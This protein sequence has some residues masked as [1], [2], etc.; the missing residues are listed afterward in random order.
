MLL[1][2]VEG[3]GALW[4][5][6][7]GEARG[8]DSGLTQ[9]ILSKL[10]IVQGNRRT[11]AKRLLL[12]DRPPWTGDLTWTTGGITPCDIEESPALGKPLLMPNDLAQKPFQAQEPDFAGL[13]MILGEHGKGRIA[14]L[15]DVDWLKLPAWEALSPTGPA[16]PHNRL[17]LD[18][19]LNWT[20]KA[21]H[22]IP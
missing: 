10:G 21:G 5:M 15:G 16:V 17:L 11:G 3:G 18:R 14:I 19:L 22:A 6:I 12:P 13:A 20:L 2:Y 4:V 1:R 8:P 9:A 7:Q